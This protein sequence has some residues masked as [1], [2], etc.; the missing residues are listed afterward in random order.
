M[1]YY[2]TGR[3]PGAKELSELCCTDETDKDVHDWFTI[4]V[5]CFLAILNIHINS[6][7]VYVRF[8]LVN[9]GF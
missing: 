6:T 5:E 9:L 2:E 7:N 8:D 4:K 3:R 1:F